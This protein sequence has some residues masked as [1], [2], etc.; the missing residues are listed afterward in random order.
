MAYPISGRTPAPGDYGRDIAEMKRAITQLQRLMANRPKVPEQVAAGGIV[1]QA[2]LASQG[3]TV[4]ALAGTEGLVVNAPRYDAPAAADGGDTPTWVHTDS[5]SPW[6]IKC[7]E[8]WYS[9]VMLV[10][11]AWD[12]EAAAPEALSPSMLGGWDNPHQDYSTFARARIGSGQWGLYVYLNH[13]LT[14]MHAADYFQASVRYNGTTASTDS[15]FGLINWTI[16]KFE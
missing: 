1:G 15:T 9:A 7:D 6:Q 5:S 4:Q 8:G 11:L 3:G 12:S 14:Y 2:T 16:T 10:W 13:G